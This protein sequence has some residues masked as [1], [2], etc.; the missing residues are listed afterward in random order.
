VMAE[1]ATKEDLKDLSKEIKDHITLLIDPM[2]KDINDVEIVL[3]GKSRVNGVAGNQKTMKTQINIIY[4][5]LTFTSAAIAGTC[6]K[7]IWF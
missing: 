1:H 7:L 2:K 6:I 5:L 4:G 3:L